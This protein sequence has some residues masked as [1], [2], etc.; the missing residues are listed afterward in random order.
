MTVDVELSFVTPV[1]PSLVRGAVGALVERYSSPSPPSCRRSSDS[2]RCSKTMMTAASPR[3]TAP[4]IWVL[5]SSAPRDTRA[6]L[7]LAQRETREGRRSAALRA[8]APRAPGQL[9][10]SGRRFSRVDYLLVL[11]DAVW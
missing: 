7:A 5:G 6:T 1:T 2:I 4:R 10:R 3:W 9:R 8:A 11:D